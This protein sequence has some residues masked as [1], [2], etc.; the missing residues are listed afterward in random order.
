[1]VSP[2]PHLPLCILIITI[3]LDLDVEGVL[4]VGDVDGEG[5]DPKAVVNGIALC[6][7]DGGGQGGGGG[8]DA[9]TRVGR[10]EEGCLEKQPTPPS[11]PVPR[12]GQ[13]GLW[14]RAS[15]YLGHPITNLAWRK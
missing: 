3:Q 15:K 10:G 4:G 9:T 2:P 1:M 13:A 8:G 7:A 14:H 5:V 6:D 12:Q 11:R